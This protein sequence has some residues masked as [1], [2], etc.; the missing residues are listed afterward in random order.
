MELELLNDNLCAFWQLL[1]TTRHVTSRYFCLDCVHIAQESPG[2]SHQ[3]FLAE[4]LSMLLGSQMDMAEGCSLWIWLQSALEPLSFQ[5]D[6]DESDHPWKIAEW[7]RRTLNSCKSMVPIRQRDDLKWK[8]VFIFLKQGSLAVS[9]T[10][11]AA[12]PVH[13]LVAGNIWKYQVAGNAGNKISTKIYSPCIDKLVD[14]GGSGDWDVLGECSELGLRQ[15]FVTGECAFARS[16]GALEKHK[17]QL[18]MSMKNCE[19]SDFSKLSFFSC[20]PSPSKCF[21]C[22]LEETVTFCSQQ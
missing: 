19:T 8:N 2:C 10:W 21:K 14:G 17:G 13:M 11:S 22:F 5:G 7:E 1:W 16:R 12:I 9:Q 18:S 6:L 3:H 15:R 4:C 20:F